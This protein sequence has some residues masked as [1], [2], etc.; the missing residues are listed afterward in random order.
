MAIRVGVKILKFLFG[1][2]HPLT[3][4]PWNP[5]QTLAIKWE[6]NI[7]LKKSSCVFI[8]VSLWCCR[9]QYNRYPWP[10]LATFPYCA[11]PLAG[12]QEWIPYPHIAA[13]CMF[14]LIVLLLLG[15]M[16][17]SIGVHHLWACLCFS[18]SVLRVWFIHGFIYSFS[19]FEKF[20]L[21]IYN[22]QNIIYPILIL[23][24]SIMK[25][26]LEKEK[27]RFFCLFWSHI[28]LVGRVL[29]KDPE[30]LGSIPV[31]I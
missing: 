23:I 14:E 17:G 24:L 26:L 20:S 10:S 27:I 4:K 6:V 16:W 1:L 31:S 19:K 29:A 28:G 30:D 11:S 18:S 25:S 5:F 2:Q 15:H 21:N 7:L 9:W 13:V 8:I 12:L 3:R 22:I